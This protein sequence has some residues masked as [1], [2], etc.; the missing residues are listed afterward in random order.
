MEDLHTII[1]H[2]STE[3]SQGTGIVRVGR[4]ARGRPGRQS[5][6]SGKIDILNESID[7]LCSTN[8][9]VPNK[10]KVNKV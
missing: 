2:E 7:Y 9:I 4:L 1:E 5:P 3:F 10:R 8:I 6:R